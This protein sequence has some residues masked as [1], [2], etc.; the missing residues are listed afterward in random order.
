[1]KRKPFY[2]YKRQKQ[3]SSYYYVCYIDPITGKQKNAKSL[4]TLKLKLGLG[5]QSIEHKEEA[6]LIAYKALEYG[7]VLNNESDIPFATYCLNFWQYSTSTYVNLRNKIK[8][9]SLSKEYCIN[10]LS[11]V[12]NHVVTALDPALSLRGIK[13]YHLDKIVSLAFNKDLSNGTIQQIILSFSI[14]LKEAVRT[15]LI[16]YNPAINLLKIPR[17]EKPR[18]VFTNDEI[19]SILTY[20]KTINNNIRL[21]IILAIVTGMRSGEIRALKTNSIIRNYITDSNKSY[22][23]II[24]EKSISPYSGEK[25]TKSKYSRFVLIPSDLGDEL[26]NNANY[27]TL[28][29]QS[30]K[31]DYLS[32]TSLRLEFYKVLDKLNIDRI[33]RNLT[34]HSLRHYFATYTK[35]NKVEDL[36]R[37][38]VLGHKSLKVNKR[39]THISDNSLLEIAALCK[40]LLT[41]AEESADN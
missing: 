32:S 36:I 41:N 8:S 10:M 18:G 11:N 35:E 40:T 16:Y 7:L 17:N 4:D 12:K 39:Y 38:Q 23:K 1:M 28:V 24:I 26:Y 2:I 29:V 37:M 13:T 20:I 31:G 30:T 15:G 6:I 22:D 27:T 21:S 34:F 19:Y 3:N 5:I 14:P 25:S 33:E 9:D